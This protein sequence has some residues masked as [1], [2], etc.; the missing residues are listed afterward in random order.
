MSVLGQLIN[1]PVR[2]DITSKAIVAAEVIGWLGAWQ[3]GRHLEMG[4]F[5]KI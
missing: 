4:E 3:W 5:L 2:V 1:C